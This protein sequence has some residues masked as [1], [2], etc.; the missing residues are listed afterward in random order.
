MAAAVLSLAL[1]VCAADKAAPG[2]AQLQRLAL[3]QD[4][5]LEWKDDEKRMGPL[6]DYLRTQFKLGKDGSFAPNA[7]LN[8][9]GWNVTHVYPESVGMAVGFSL[10]MDSGFA[11][12]RAAVEKQLGKP[13]SCDTSDGFTACEL[14]IAPKKIATILTPDNGKAKTTL[15]GC[16]YFYQK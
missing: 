5:W 9:M 3:C 10:V 6:R 16:G 12:T 14:Q 13:M 7:P 1:P 11:A 4:S 15:I 8:V 2:P